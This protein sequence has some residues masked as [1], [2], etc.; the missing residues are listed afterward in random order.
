MGWLDYRL[1]SAGGVKPET[2][3]ENMLSSHSGWGIGK[4]RGWEFLTAKIHLNISK[5]T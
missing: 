3:N 2:V 4:S 5:L 1:K